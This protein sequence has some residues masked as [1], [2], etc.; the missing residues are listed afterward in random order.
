MKTMGK[1]DGNVNKGPGGN[2]DGRRHRAQRSGWR[3]ASG[4]R[5]PLAGCTGVLVSLHMP[6]HYHRGNN[7]VTD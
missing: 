1:S 4:E 7:S 5:T 6:R 2:A 3:E